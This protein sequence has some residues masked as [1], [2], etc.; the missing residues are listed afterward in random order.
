MATTNSITTSYAGKEAGKY[1]APA[2]LNS[3]TLASRALTI[4][5]GIKFK[6]PLRPTTV[7]GLIKDAS[8]D[9]NATG[10][11]TTT[12]RVLQP[13]ELQVNLQFCKK[14]F[15]ETWDAKQLVNSTHDDLPKNFSDFIIAQQIA[16]VA[17]NNE[18]SIWTGDSTNGGEYDGFTTLV[19]A[20]ANLP[21]GQEV[22]GTTITPANVRDEIGSVIDA[23]PER[24]LSRPDFQ[25]YVSPKVFRAYK[26]ALGNAG[27]LDR[28]N[29]QDIN[30]TE[31]DGIKIFKADG[32]S[33][34]VMFAS[35]VEN[36]HFGT[37]LIADHNEVK[38]IDMSEKDGSQNVRFVMRF[39]GGVQ[40]ALAQDIVTYGITNSAN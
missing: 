37:S 13:K 7:T 28:F 31:F 11:V 40:Y 33:G 24:V 38:L 22:A 18:T 23:T 9:F 10:T 1:I 2:L 15:R 8:C 32:L 25:V 5:E 29:N 36:L 30:A 16:Q 35:Y 14:G 39:T 26:R 34:D 6:K 3:P 21:S 12:E 20:D 17:Q 19:A 4:N 27:Y